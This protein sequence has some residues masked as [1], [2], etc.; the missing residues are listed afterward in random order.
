MVVVLDLFS[1]KPIGWGMLFSPDSALTGKV[2]TMV[3]ESRG[4]PVGIMFYSDQK[5]HYIRRK[6][7]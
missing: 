7:R 6:F 3:W 2:F 4:K 1:R 5:S